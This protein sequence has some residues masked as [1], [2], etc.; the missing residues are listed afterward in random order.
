MLKKLLLISLLIRLA[1]FYYGLYQDA[2]MPIP[3]TDIDYYVFTD[4]ARYTYNNE[5]P[6]KRLTYRYTPLLALILQ[7]TAIEGWFSFGKYIFIFCDL[8]TGLLILISLP[9]KYKLLSCIWLLNPMVITISTRGSSESLLTSVILLSTYL[10]SKNVILSGLILGV[11]IHLKIYPVIYIPTYL[12]YID[13]QQSLLKPI[14]LKRIAFLV[15]VLFS[16]SLLTYWMYIWY[17]QEYLDEAILYHFSRLDHRHNFSIYNVPLYIN[18]YVS[19]SNI[20]LEK[21]AFIPQL[22][23]VVL[24]PLF[25]KPNPQTIYKLMFIQTL[26]FVT[27]NKVCT[28]QYFI[29]YLCLLPQY[30]VGS[31]L[32]LE[33]TFI[34]VLLWV[35][36]QAYWLYNGWLLE[37]K[38]QPHI[39]S[40]IYFAATLFFICNVYLAGTFISDVK[41][42]VALM[43]GK[44]DS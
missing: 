25:I 24:V 2:H 34:L 29:W 22:G 16:A 8:I 5:S 9:K 33:K 3:Y 14:T 35:I 1:F 12:L 41:K 44:K 30:I 23:L 13:S 38:G 27:F 17:G 36:T 6:F 43:H 19:N 39:F 37:F 18:S 20:S 42:Q 32:T 4:A 26:I 40:H 7:P 11:A 10:L 21:I 31:T 28:S 15:S